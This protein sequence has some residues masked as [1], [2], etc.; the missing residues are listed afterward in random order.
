M[1]SSFEADGALPAQSSKRKSDIA[2]V[3]VIDLV[4]TD[5][6]VGQSGEC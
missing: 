2:N 5:A 3:D 6:E 1:R 4:E